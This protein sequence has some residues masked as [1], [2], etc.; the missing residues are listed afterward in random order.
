R[1]SQEERDRFLIGLGPPEGDIGELDRT[2]QAWK[3]RPA[4][5][6]PGFQTGA[7]PV[8]G[9]W[10]LDQYRQRVAVAFNLRHLDL[11][12]VLSSCRSQTELSELF[13]GTR[14]ALRRRGCRRPRRLNQ[15]C[16]V[17]V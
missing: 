4:L 6:T 12:R 8:D 11:S 1:L 2:G 7:L 15:P 16:D 5:G 9:L 3:G 14:L 10:A 17:R 13:K